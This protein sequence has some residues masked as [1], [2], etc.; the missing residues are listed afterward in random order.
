[1][2]KTAEQAEFASLLAKLGS[3][4]KGSGSQN[5]FKR[6]DIRKSDKFCFHCGVAG[7]L[8]ENC[9]KLTSVVPDWYKEIIEKKKV[10]AQFQSQPQPHKTYAANM[11]VTVDTPLHSFNS[12]PDFG[13][14]HFLVIY[15]LKWTNI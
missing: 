12:K 8:K 2:T 7:H 1:M 4:I 14:D 3:Q 13:K 6:K 5:N 11:S 15:I 9:F 10:A